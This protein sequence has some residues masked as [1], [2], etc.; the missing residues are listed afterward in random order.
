METSESKAEQEVSPTL[1]ESANDLGWTVLIAKNR[2]DAFNHE[3]IRRDLDT[4]RSAGKKRLA[5]DLSAN[6]FLSLPMIRY[7]VELAASL[8]QDGGSFALL[9]CQPKTKRHFEIYGSLENILFFR[10]ERELA[11]FAKGSSLQRVSSGKVTLTNT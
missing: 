2:V 1:K 9:G 3:E 7:C 5:L 8:A 10:F 6:R 4:L 11:A